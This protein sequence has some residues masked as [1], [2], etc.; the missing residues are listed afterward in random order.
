MSTTEHGN[1]TPER[2]ADLRSLRESIVN[3]SAVVNTQTFTF[4]SVAAFLFITAASVTNLDLLIGTKITLPLLNVQVNIQMFFFLA[5][6]L[7]ILFHAYLLVQ[8]N[9]LCKRLHQYQKALTKLPAVSQKFEWNTLPPFLFIQWQAGSRY[10]K[11]LQFALGAVNW[12]AYVYAPILLTLYLQRVFLPY[13]NTQITSVHVILVII[14]I[15]IVWFF[16]PNTRIY[17]YLST[18]NLRARKISALSFN[19]LN[20]GLSL[21]VVIFSIG[22]LIDQN[23]Y[24]YV[25]LSWLQNR[26]SALDVSNR[27][28]SA[29]EPAPEIMA[30]LMRENAG[31]TM[32]DIQVRGLL[33]PQYAA[34]LNLVGRNLRNA[35]FSGS[36]LIGANFSGA[37]LRGATLDDALLV[38]SH[39]YKANLSGSSI[40]R[41]V[42]DGSTVCPEQVDRACIADFS[43]A[44][45]QG[46]SL[47]AATLD[48]AD[49][50]AVDL[51]Q[52]DLFI[53]SMAKGKFVGAY[54]D[55]SYLQRASFHGTDLT[56]ASFRGAYIAG[57]RFDIGTTVKQTDFGSTKG[58]TPSQEQRRRASMVLDNVYK[59]ENRRKE[60]KEALYSSLKPDLVEPSTEAFH[61]EASFFGD[62]PMDEIKKMFHL[63]ELNKELVRVTDRDL[64]S[65]IIVSIYC[66]GGEEYLRRAALSLVLDHPWPTGVGSLVLGIANECE[67]ELSTIVKRVQERYLRGP[68]NRARDTLCGLQDYLG[69]EVSII[70]MIGL[71]SMDCSVF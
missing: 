39:F 5:P 19:F 47:I 37:D 1:L 53:S 58:M 60:F 38:G 20:C 57:I 66:D 52:S 7:S 68:L 17:D 34:S 2:L 50:T 10:G 61:Y 70:E 12:I 22:F 46:A 25:H 43:G 48:G 6:P 30:E 32:K 21:I 4:I 16:W 33:I 27:V 23:Q 55:G 26:F 11:R 42:L 49:F 63:D 29:R 69:A 24:G 65:E 28:L 62:P 8:L 40:R 13:Q 56:G 59:D 54:F 14:Q 51:S 31:S 41:A 15:L 9:I 18:P 35:D 45:L 71:R 3:S 64:N 67:N 44:N 36:T